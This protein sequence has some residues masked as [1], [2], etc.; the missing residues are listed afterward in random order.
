[1]LGICFVLMKFYW[2]VM[3]SYLIYFV[4][5]CLFVLHGFCFVIAVSF[6]GLYSC[7][8]GW[9]FYVVCLTCFYS[10]LLFYKE[11]MRKKEN[12][13]CWLGG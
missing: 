5:F 11:R 9:L 8:F 3:V 13:C 4:S 10:T 6:V 7:L 1:M 12:A 2:S